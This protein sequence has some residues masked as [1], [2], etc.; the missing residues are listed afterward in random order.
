MSKHS[1][2][3]VQLP[4]F[5]PITIKLTK[6]YETIID[7]IDAD[8]V[9]LKWTAAIA[10]NGIPYAKH[11]LKKEG[12]FQDESLHRIILERILGRSLGRG[13]EGDHINNDTMDNRRENLRLATRSQQLQNTRRRSDSTSGYKGVY[14]R[15]DTGKWASQISVNKRRICLGSFNTPEDAYSAY[16]EAAKEYFGEF[17][18]L[19]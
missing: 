18:R 4:L 6:G 17:A 12:R 15:N 14:F 9:G 7:P 13:E 1:P 10:N 11:R 3:S 19:K 5:D 2:D 16:C 8:L